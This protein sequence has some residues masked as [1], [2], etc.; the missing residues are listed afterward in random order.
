MWNC[1]CG[2]KAIAASL[3]SCPVCKE[4]RAMPNTTMAGTT[5]AKALPGE[6]G[7]VP[8]EVLERLAQSPEDADAPDVAAEVVSAPAVPT[9]A[10]IPIPLP[11]T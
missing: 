1:A 6:P 10:P 2:C 3:G 9:P 11:A 7:Y 5:N 8:P 4:E